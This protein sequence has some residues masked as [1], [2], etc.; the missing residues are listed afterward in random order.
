[1]PTSIRPTTFFRPTK[2]V[3][4]S[5]IILIF[6]SLSAFADTERGVLI[7]P[8]IIYLTPDR[9]A[10]KLATMSR[11]DEVVVLEKSHEWIHVLA[12]VHSGQEHEDEEGGFTNAHDISGW[13][14]DKGAV[15]ASTPKAVR[16]CLELLPRPKIKPAV[17]TV[18]KEQVR[19]PFVCIPVQRNTSLNRRWP[20]RR[21][22]AR[23]TSA[24]NW[25]KKT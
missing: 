13:I 14:L 9:S 2:L 17:P 5:T 1:M 18:A 19:K 3:L 10:E 20:G 11:G 21:Y 16:F 8:A 12:T 23:A 24:G 25:I 4:F 7:Y 6:F 22:T 15:R